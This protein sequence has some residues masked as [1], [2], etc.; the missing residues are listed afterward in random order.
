MA[1]LLACGAA[2]HHNFAVATSNFSGINWDSKD[3]PTAEVRRCEHPSCDLDGEYR[4]PKSRSALTEYY[5][6]CLEHVREYNAT[7][8]FFDGMDESEIEQFRVR[9][10][11]W[12]R[13]TWK[14]GSNS[15]TTADINGFH[16]DFGLLGTHTRTGAA[17]A[18]EER[19][20]R[21]RLAPDKKALAVLDL[22]VYCTIDEIKIRYKELVK[23]F[24]PDANGGSKDTEDRLKDINQAYS[25]LMSRARA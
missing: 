13:P 14:L 23:R 22:S 24:H 16:D 11:T 4:A 17:Q 21:W 25:F 10:M 9:D 12:H 7:W 5:W 19:Q 20:P 3:E 8:D 1:R 15:A 2:S 6:F 18:A